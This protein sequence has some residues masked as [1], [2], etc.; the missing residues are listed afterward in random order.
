MCLRISEPPHLRAS[1]SDAFARHQTRSLC[2]T[3]GKHGPHVPAISD[4][5]RIFSRVTPQ[6]GAHVR[7]GRP[8]AR[9]HPRHCCRRSHPRAP[10]GLTHF[11]ERE[12]SFLLVSLLRTK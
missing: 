11:K 10:A 6:A 12:K 7:V 4:H 3:A 8:L 1:P 9:G 5:P 2:H